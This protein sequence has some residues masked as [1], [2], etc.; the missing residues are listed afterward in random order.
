MTR[1][2]RM[3]VAEPWNFVGPWGANRLQGILVTVG[4]SGG[5]SREPIWVLDFGQII[6]S[7]ALATRYGLVADRD[8]AGRLD[9]EGKAQGRFGLSIGTVPLDVVK[10]LPE[11]FPR[12]EAVAKFMAIAS[13]ED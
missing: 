10:V 7:E 2:V 1:L 5:T 12:L 8:K 3:L 6:R 11:E 4:A 9:W 13:L